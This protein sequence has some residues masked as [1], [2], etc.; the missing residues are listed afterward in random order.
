MENQKLP[1]PGEIANLL[2]EC[3]ATINSSD[4]NP[5]VLLWFLEMREDKLLTV[6]VLGNSGDAHRAQAVIDFLHAE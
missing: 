4:A 6:I 3:E 2:N 1:T 5:Q